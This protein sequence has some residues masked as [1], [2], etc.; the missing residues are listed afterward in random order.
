MGQYMP[1][2][3]LGEIPFYGE[4]MGW[5]RQ[6]HIYKT[7]FYYIDYCLAQTVALEFWA[8]I[9]RD[10]Q[11]AFETYLSYTCLLYTSRCV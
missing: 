11:T 5:Q 1:W 8:R 3:K 6:S 10:P 7:P 9:Q 2:V 4:A